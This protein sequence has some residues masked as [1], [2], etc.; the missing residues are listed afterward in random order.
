M[1]ILV[2]GSR[3]FKDR[4]LMTNR[5]FHFG[6]DVVVIHGGAE[7]ADKMA[8]EIAAF[9]GLKV[10]VFPADWKTHGKKAGPLRN[11]RMLDEGKPDHVVAFPL[12]GSVGTWDMIRRAQRAGISL[13]VVQ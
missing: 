13:E 8:G 2:C 4:D 3:H 6:R 11:Q 12:E 1:R 9:L 5:M 10:E 7:G